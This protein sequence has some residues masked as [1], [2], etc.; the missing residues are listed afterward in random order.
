MKAKD[1]RQSGE[2]LLATREEGM[3]KTKGRITGIKERKLV[4]FF[5]Q[6]TATKAEIKAG[7]LREDIKT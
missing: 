7:Y 4:C 6:T 5:R 3:T 2:Q 1:K